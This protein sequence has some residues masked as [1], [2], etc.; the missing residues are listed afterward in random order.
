M[1]IARALAVRP[2]LLVCDEPVS[3]L[4]VSIQAQILNLFGELRRELGI[5][6]LFITHDLAVVRQVVERL[7]VLYRGTIIET[8]AVDRVL[9]AP[10]EDYTRRLVDSVP[11]GEPS[12]LNA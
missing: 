9:D 3:A 12:W 4:D 2:R 5:A 1:A 8:G 10:R 6:Y 7:Y 11:S